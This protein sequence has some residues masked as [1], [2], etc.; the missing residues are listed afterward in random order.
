[1]GVRIVKGRENIATYA[2]RLEDLALQCG[3]PGA[4]NWLRYFLEVSRVRRKHPYLVLLFAA[5]TG[6]AAD[7]LVAAVLFFEYFALGLPTRGFATDDASAFRTVI[8]PP[9]Q[10]GE[11]AVCAIRAMLQHGAQGVFVSYED[12]GASPP[13][14]TFAD[15]PA[16]QWAQRRRDFD[17][18]LTLEPTY[19][20]TLA[21]F[22][23]TTRVNLRYY[24][25]KLLAKMDCEFVPDARTLLSEETLLA[26]N[27]S[28]HY[29]FIP[30]RC[31]LQL[32]ASRDLPG[33]FLMALRGPGGEWMSLLGGWRQGRMS[34]LHWQLNA[35]GYEK[36]SLGTVMRSYLLE[37]EISLGMRWLS[38]Y[39]GTPHSISNAFDRSEVWDLVVRRRTWRF[40]ALRLV[41]YFVSSPRS[42]IGRTN[43]MAAAFCRDDLDW[44]NHDPDR[45]RGHPS[46]SPAEPV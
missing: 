42:V 36:D 35:P 32:E 17:K 14:P 33:G 3:Q 13:L 39:G 26:L 31:L 24:R 4:M 30:R 38:F 16:L 12:P 41:S 27:E 11:I 43:M 37:H 46:S 23:K 15:A 28:S 1:M 9:G 18:T 8:A 20:A 7:D 40:A 19:D 45:H 29:P 2:P 44:Q 25:R 6:P 5:S 22:G 34:V 10:R 21:K